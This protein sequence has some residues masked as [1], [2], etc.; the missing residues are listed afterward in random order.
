M[1]S[2]N[3]RKILFGHY[4]RKSPIHNPYIKEDLSMKNQTQYRFAMLADR[5]SGTS[6]M[7]RGIPS[8]H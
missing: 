3:Q 4:D 2:A 7:K 5:L 6:E 8:W 1:I